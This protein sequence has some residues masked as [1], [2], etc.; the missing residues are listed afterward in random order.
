MFVTPDQELEDQVK[1]EYRKEVEKE[2]GVE[3]N[4]WITMVIP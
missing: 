3:H 4:I 2:A 1:S